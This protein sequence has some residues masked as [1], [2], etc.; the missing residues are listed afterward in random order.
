MGFTTANTLAATIFLKSP[1]LIE[2]MIALTKSVNCFFDVLFCFLL[3]A[4]FLANV[5]ADDFM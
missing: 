5:L 2:E 1:D 4:I 3:T